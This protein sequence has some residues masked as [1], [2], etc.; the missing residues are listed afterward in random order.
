MTVIK[1]LSSDGFSRPEQTECHAIAD[2]FSGKIAKA[3]IHKRRK[4]LHDPP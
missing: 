2:R 3:R 1:S 4:T